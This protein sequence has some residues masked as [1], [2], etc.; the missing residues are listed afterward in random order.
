[1]KFTYEGSVTI[2]VS[3][4]D[5]NL[6][7]ISVSDTGIGMT[8]SALRKILS[9]FKIDANKATSTGLGLGLSIS[10][11]LALSLGPEGSRATSELTRGS[12]FF[13]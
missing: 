8:S 4:K 11:K 9:D 13:F 12:S 3:K 1:M 2:K 10:N 5:C 6:I 7:E